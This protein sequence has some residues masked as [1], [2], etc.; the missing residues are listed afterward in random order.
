MMKSIVVAALAIC[1][2]VTMGSMHAQ[3]PGPR[4]QNGRILP[5]IASKRGDRQIDS[6]AL[7]LVRFENRLFRRRIRADLVL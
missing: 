2:G 7:N 4:G 6:S 3:A 5:P 1:V